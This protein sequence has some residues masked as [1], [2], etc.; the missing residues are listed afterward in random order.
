MNKAKPAPSA[1]PSGLRRSAARLMALEQRFMFDGAAV[2]DAVA[3][4]VDI[5]VAT[6]PPAVP[7]FSTGRL[8]PIGVLSAQRSS[9]APEIPTRRESGI[10]ELKDFSLEAYYVFMAP[11]KTPAGVAGKIEADVL[12]VAAVPELR[13]KL[14]GA[15]MDMMVLNAAAMPAAADDDDGG[16]GDDNDD[17]ATAGRR[18]T[19][20]LSVPPRR[21]ATARSARTDCAMCMAANMLRVRARQHR[22]VAA[23]KLPKRAHVKVDSNGKR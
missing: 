21:C 14:S 11:P 22:F 16:G 13:T 12:K 4:Q 17:R 5:V 1:Q 8:R 9:S 20:R 18:K 15:G 10:P 19:P 6:L 3:G 23:A 2:A 7:F